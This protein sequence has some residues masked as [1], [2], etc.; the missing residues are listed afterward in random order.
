MARAA[1]E[2][3]AAKLQLAAGLCAMAALL[4]VW[5]SLTE[6]PHPALPALF[7]LLAVAD[8]AVAGRGVNPVA[9]RELLAHVPPVV[10][11]IAAEPGEHRVFSASPTLAA[12]NQGLVRGPA[13]W[14][15]EWSYALGLQESLQAP[16]AAAGVS[17][18]A[19]TPT[20]P[21]WPRWP[22]RSS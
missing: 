16:S 6:H 10:R 3:L 18:A 19:T 2:P 11:A 8:L 17:G 4:A 9:P 7:G 13:G 1:Y 22:R 12:L 21:G 20:S 15:P 5:R 14:R